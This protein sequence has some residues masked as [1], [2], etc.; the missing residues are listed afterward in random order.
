M[1]SG[2][3]KNVRVMGIP[4]QEPVTVANAEQCYKNSIVSVLPT[5][6]IEVNLR[7]QDT[8][9]IATHF[10]SEENEKTSISSRP[11][12]INNENIPDNE[13]KPPVASQFPPIRQARHR[14]EKKPKSSTSSIPPISRTIITEK[15]ESSTLTVRLPPLHTPRTLDI[16]DN[17]LESVSDDSQSDDVAN[18][19]DDWRLMSIPNRSDF[20]GDD[21]FFTSTPI[22]PSPEHSDSDEDH[23]ET[24]N[25]LLRPLSNNIGSYD[26]RLSAPLY[27]PR[28]LQAPEQANSDRYFQPIPIPDLAL[29]PQTLYSLGDRANL[30]MIRVNEID[31]SNVA[32]NSFD[33]STIYLTHSP[34]VIKN[35]N[36]IPQQIE[37]LFSEAFDEAFNMLRQYAIENSSYRLI[38]EAWRPNSI[39]QLVDQ[40]KKFPTNKTI[41]DQLWIV[42]YWIAR[43]IEYDTL[44]YVGKKLADKSAEAVFRSRK[45]IGDGYA[46][47]FRR[48][49]DDLDL[50]CEKVHGYAKTYI[51]DPHN[52]S[53]VPI[54]HVWNAVQISQYWY[55]VD[56]TCGA[57]YLDENQVFKRELNP[58]Y[59]LPPPNELIYH[60]LPAAERWQ[61]LKNPINMAQY[62]QMPKLWPQ[63]FQHDLRLLYPNDT[64]HVD[65]DPRQSYATVLI[66]APHAI[67]LVAA[68]TLNEKEVDGGCQIVYD[69]RKHLYSCDFAPTSTGVHLIRFYARNDRIEN[70]SLH[71][72]AQFELDVRQI[73]SK[74]V[75]FPKTWRPFFDL[76][77]EI[78][79][80][81]DTHS[82]KMD[83]GDT[84]T[85][86]LIRAPSD[87]ELVGRLAAENNV[88]IAGGY[89]TYLDRRKGVWRCLFAPNHDGLFDAF[90]LAKR[91]LDPGS[92]TMAARFRIKAKRIPSPPLSYPRTWQLFHDLD[93]HIESPRNSATVPWP[94]FASYAQICIR[95]PDDVRLMS[96]IERNGF[97]VE[98][99]SL[100]Q[101]NREKQYWQLF[102]APE[103]M[104]EHKLLI[105]V[106]C[107]TPDGVISGIAAEFY[108]NVTQLRHAV[109]FPV[110]YSTFLMKKCRIHEPIDGVLKKNARVWIHCEIPNARQVDLTIDSKWIKTEGYQDSILK[111]QIIV[112]S[113]DVI[114]Y[115]KY[116]EN[117][118]Y[119][120]LI[121]YTVQ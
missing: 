70:S 93:L 67:N 80:P 82:I 63:F 84:H 112:G 18:L 47:L 12:E 49:C 38:I 44:P 109:K 79:W 114:I 25:Y 90:I 11:P 42:F 53:T 95:T 2:C 94:E 66:Q 73:P 4:Q 16:D 14:A 72:V 3:C 64:V 35:R 106:H 116:D 20:Y 78:I 101:F 97:R 96:C 9:S 22:P 30:P 54:D 110:I 52:K 105:F 13:F 46:N 19:D 41:L 71:I 75:S 62:M 118:I 28:V 77:L 108:L 8:Q 69:G 88:R 45:A 24:L 5:L 7:K 107:S 91:R 31:D 87:V 100:T 40:I 104:G 23:I 6:P 68:F 32:K 98:N 27:M 59:F 102:F 55:L 115:A 1:G 15:T 57:G 86:I 81:I 74:I 39:E 76:N 119:N 43:N 58:Y 50:T 121:K 33:D 48:L 60:H 103:R 37:L 56:V 92:F 120:E 17:L 65:L 34:I 117:T 83:H 26:P 36:N 113:K 99:G 29:S 10:N 21:R 111:R 51:F 85:E 61:L 89:C